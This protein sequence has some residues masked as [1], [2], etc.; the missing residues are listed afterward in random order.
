[1]GLAQYPSSLVCTSKK[2]P[3]NPKGVPEDSPPVIAVE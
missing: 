2:R 1:M 3:P